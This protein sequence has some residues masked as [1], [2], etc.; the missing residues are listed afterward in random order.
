MDYDKLSGGYW[1]VNSKK[2]TSKFEAMIY[3]TEIKQPIN[4]IFFDSVWRSFNKSSLGNRN[5][6]DLYRQR[7]Q[8]LR[9]EYDYL[10]LYFSGGADSYNV[11]RSFIDNG[12]KLDEICVKWPMITVNKELYCPNTEDKT[13]FNY[14]SEWNYAIKPV[15]DQLAQTHPE[16]KIEIVDWSKD[17]SPSVYSEELIKKVNVWNDIE[18]PMMVSYSN[19]EILLLD[20][21]KR[22]ASIYGIDKPIVGY[23]EDKW[24]MNFPDTAT[25]MG[26]SQLNDAYNVEYFYWTPKMPEIAFEQ[27]HKV[28][29]YLEKNQSLLKYFF[30]PDPSFFESTHWIKSRQIQNDIIKTLV[31][32]TWSNVFQSDKPI[33]ADREDKQFWIF[34]NPEFVK[35]RDSFIDLNSLALSQVDSPFYTT[36]LKGIQNKNKIRGAFRPSWSKWHF[37][38]FKEMF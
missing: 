2:F 30:N 36:E 14:L 20:K 25:G 31:Y 21:A 5:L 35:H 22:V 4:F 38:K 10:I 6:N 17:Y 29:C 19:S 32:N 27:A 9:D 23:Q 1:E 34:N 18:M 26:I 37:V 11:L 3:A 24:F 33:F 8:Q 28:C 16:I 15:L 13:A 7:A 12:I